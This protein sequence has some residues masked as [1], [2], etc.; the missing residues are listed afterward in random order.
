MRQCARVCFFSAWGQTERLIVSIRSDGLTCLSVN[1]DL[2]TYSL[3]HITDHAIHSTT[4]THS[5]SHKSSTVNRLWSPSTFTFWTKTGD[6]RGKRRRRK[7]GRKIRSRKEKNISCVLF[8]HV[9]LFIMKWGT[10]VD[11]KHEE[12]LFHICLLPLLV[13]W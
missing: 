9:F 4:H 6:N 10:E 7:S 13:E 5:H 3:D 12:T 2:E 1:S 11:S 8:K